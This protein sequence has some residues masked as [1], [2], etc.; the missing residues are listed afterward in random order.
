MKKKIAILG[1]TGSIGKTLLDIISKDKNNFQ[2]VLLTANKNYKLLLLQAKKFKVKNV[3]LTNEKVFK[4]NKSIFI[5]YK[6]KIF[7]NFNNLDQIIKNKID[8]T[9]SSIVGIQGL[10]PT[11]NLIKFTKKI[12]IA[13]KESIICGWNLIK[14]KLDKY[15]TEF[16][17]VDS[18][19]FSLWYGLQ[20]L[21]KE[22]IDK[23]YLT[24][25]GG[26]FYKTSLKKFKDI[27][28]SQALK[29]PNWKMGKKISIDSA[30]M[31]NKVYEVIEAK[32]I[33]NI[34]YDRIKILVHPQSYVHAMIKFKNGLNKI[35]AH[36]TTMEIPI[37]NTLFFNK[38]K[39]YIKSGRLD[40]F[41]LNN[42]NLTEVS[43][44]RFPMINLLKVLPHK[45]SLYETVIVSANDT[46]VNLYLN[47]KIKFTQIQKELFKIIKKQEFL[48]YKKIYPNNVKHIID[49]NN[50]VH[51]KT[52]KNVY[53]S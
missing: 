26:P 24:A 5:K 20:N 45:T 29:H 19:H 4:K 10:N 34:A 52:I 28:V 32:N 37:Y 33:F 44:K 38:K 50:Y 48:K 8:Y 51:L 49:L 3:I 47:K 18:E 30:T 46:L 22:N 6:I 25:S 14:K 40:L 36:D 42:L 17:P 43:I 16:I 27:K 1:S 7:N 9:M 53:K 35:I 23:I 13:N 12:A 31:I 39:K 15:K 41:K 2:I 11:I 21:E